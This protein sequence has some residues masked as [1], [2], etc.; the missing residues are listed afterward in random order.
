MYPFLLFIGIGDAYGAEFEFAEP[1]YVSKYNKGDKYYPYV[2]GKYTDDTQMSIALGEMLKDDIPFTKIQIAD[3]FLSAFH[4]DPRRGYSGRFYRFLLTCQSA[5]YFVDNINSKGKDTCGAAMRS[6]P[7]GL[8]ST[9]YKDDETIYDSEMY[10]YC[11]EQAR[12]THDSKEGIES[13]FAIALITNHFIYVKDPKVSVES[14]LDEHIFS[15]IVNPDFNRKVENK[16]E[17]LVNAVLSVLLKSNSITDILKNSVAFTGDVDSVAAVACGIA[18]FRPDIYK[19]DM[20]S[21]LIYNLENNRF[22]KDY[23]IKLSIELME[24]YLGEDKDA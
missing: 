3:S 13:S 11:S 5:K 6:V 10:R 20:A 22:G 14:L 17:D 9:S 8:L 23:L 19:N 1:Q 16:A 21:R 2:E 18:A 12:L 4:R 24:K 7:L 15:F